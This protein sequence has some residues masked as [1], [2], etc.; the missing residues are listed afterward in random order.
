MILG[1][2]PADWNQVPTDKDN[3]VARLSVRIWAHQSSGILALQWRPLRFA[4]LGTTIIN[5]GS[6]MQAQPPKLI[7]AIWKMPGPTNKAHLFESKSC[8]Q[9]K[10]TFEETHL[11]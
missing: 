3:L 10:K 11:W 1:V 4:S 7:S 8:C 5:H 2:F 6:A 9:K